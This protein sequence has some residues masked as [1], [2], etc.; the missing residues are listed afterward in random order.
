VT[1]AEAVLS[2]MMSLSPPDRWTALPGHEETVDARRARYASIAADVAAVADE[3]NASTSDVAL[4]VSHQLHE[5]GW[6]KDVEAPG[7]C[8]QGGKWKGR[9]DSNRAACVH[10]IQAGRRRNAV[11]RAD[12][13]ECIREGLSALRRSLATC[14]TN[15]PAHQLAGL[16]GRCAG[17]AALAGSRRIWTI[18]T[19]RAEPAMRAAMAREAS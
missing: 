7:G 12:R 13:R 2:V 6:A 16:S 8:F 18:W 14:K 1:L 5:S 4:I 15:A 17:A 11:L 19:K 10:Q 9:C 3:R